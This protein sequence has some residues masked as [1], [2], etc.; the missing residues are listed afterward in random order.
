M[1]VQLLAVARAA[2]VTARRANIARLKKNIGRRA[3]ALREAGF[4]TKA[5]ATFEELR[6]AKPQNARQVRA[7]EGRLQTLDKAKGI[8]AQTAPQVARREAA[9]RERE[10]LIERS[11]QP[12]SVNSMNADER[13]RAARLINSRLKSK[14]RNVNDNLGGSIGAERAQAILDEAPNL[15]DATHYQLAKYLA[16]SSR[17]LDFK[18]L[19]K[20]GIEE[21]KES[22]QR[23]FGRN[24]DDYSKDEVSA[25]WTALKA[26]QEKYGNKYS[27]WAVAEA[28][29]ETI[30]PA[31]NITFKHTFRN[32]TDGSGN[33]TVRQTGT[34]AFFSMADLART[35]QD[36]AARGIQLADRGTIPVPLQPKPEKSPLEKRMANLQGQRYLQQ[37][38]ANKPKPI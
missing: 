9:A 20:Q 31:Q 22:F 15:K 34:M 13:R 37:S 38:K 24:M 25:I 3:A 14:I 17:A 12:M 6:N 32:A 33:T 19:T 27:S 36:L 8:R 4:E 30:D 11:K 26:E 28:I 21:Q 16:K 10:E 18:T 1:A 29:M 2:T 23:V 35:E 7:L 5:M